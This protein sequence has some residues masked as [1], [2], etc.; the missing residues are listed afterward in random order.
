MARKR[1]PRRSPRRAGAVLVLLTVEERKRLQ[2]A[3][4]GAGLGLGP[5]IR[6]LAL[7][8]ARKERTP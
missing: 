2:E 1:V 8:E 4:A 7:R 3:A 6:M 5:W